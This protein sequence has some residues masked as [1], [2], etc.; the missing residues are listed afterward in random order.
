MT[1]PAAN[2]N[3][4]NPALP[5]TLAVDVGGTGIKAII[6]NDAGKPLTERSRIDTPPRA[7]PK[8]VLA[9]VAKLAASLG[10]FERISVGFPG[11]VRAGKVLT[12]ANLG[13][14]WIGFDLA[15]ALWQRLG[16]PARIANDADVQ[17]M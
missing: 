5:R 17:G 9:I 8:S 3:G 10:E 14:G 7:K 15:A 13:P 16:R 1:S 2:R 6:L 4:K 12:A 11:V